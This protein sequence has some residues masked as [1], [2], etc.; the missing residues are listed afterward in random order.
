MIKQTITYHP[1][2]YI[3]KDYLEYHNDVLVLHRTYNDIGE[4][5]Y[6]KTPR[7]I[8]KYHNKCKHGQQLAFHK[9]GNLYLKAF[10]IEGLIEGEYTKYNKNGEIIYKAI[11]LNDNL[12]ETLILKNEVIKYLGGFHEA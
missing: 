9:N 4:L 11:H 2:S 10:F 5:I 8:F 12:L 1:D 6:E 7:H 3:I